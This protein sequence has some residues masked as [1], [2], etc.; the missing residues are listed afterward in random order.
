MCSK[1]AK[2]TKIFQLMDACWCGLLYVHRDTEC[3]FHENGMSQGHWRVSLGISRGRCSQRNHHHCARHTFPVL[4]ANLGWCFRASVT[5][6]VQPKQ[7]L[8][9]FKRKVTAF[10]TGQPLVIGHCWKPATNSFF[11]I[12]I[13]RTS[14]ICGFLEEHLLVESKPS[15]T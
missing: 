7:I 12:S 5:G 8:V 14:I 11:S 13:Y 10:S 4:V 1:A 2:E 6:E 15:K 9:P 3:G